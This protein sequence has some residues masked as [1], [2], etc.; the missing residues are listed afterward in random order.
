[1]NRMD[2]IQTLLDSEYVTEGEKVNLRLRLSF[3]L[4]KQ[5]NNLI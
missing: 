1:M 2:R 5:R 3:Q 4:I